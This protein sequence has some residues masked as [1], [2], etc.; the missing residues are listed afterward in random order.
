MDKIRV[1]KS[2]FQGLEAIRQS[3]AT[4]MLDYRAVVQLANM[5][6]NRDTVSW[7][8]DHKH[9]YVEGVMYGIEP[10]E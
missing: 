6:N 2:V 7:L 10:E 4:N 5:L 3:G 8:M 9:E 1:P